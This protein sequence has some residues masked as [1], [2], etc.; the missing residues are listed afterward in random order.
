VF[1]SIVVPGAISTS[2]YGVNSAGEYV[3]IYEDASAGEHSFMWDGTSF[4][5]IAV[6]F[7]TAQGTEARGINDAGDLVG[8][9]SD[10]R[11][12]RGFTASP[13]PVPEPASL[14][15]LG[16]ALVGVVRAPRRRRR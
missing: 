11:V 2:I 3:G 13:T 7:A 10:G 15:V 1:T 5:L 14:I 6:P 9:W 16:T 4:S 12:I 8:D